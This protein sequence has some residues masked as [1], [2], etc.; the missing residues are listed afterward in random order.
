MRIMMG[1]LSFACAAFLLYHVIA[2]F[3]VVTLPAM[4]QL[5]QD[6]TFLYVITVGP[7]SLS[8]WQIIVFQGLLALF[9]VGFTVLGLYAFTSRQNAD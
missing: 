3:R 6:D 5:G 4:R 1:I 2:W 7:L 9:A 8:G